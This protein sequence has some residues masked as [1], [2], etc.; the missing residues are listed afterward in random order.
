MIKRLFTENLALK[1]SAVVLA[2]ILWFFVMSKGQSEISLNVPVEYTN[3]P[4]GL[5]ITKR[6]VNSV[7]VVIRTYES[8]GKNIRPDNVRVYADVSKAKSGEGFF[9]IKSDNVKVPFGATVLDIDPSTVKAFFE[10]TLS[11]KVAVEPDIT[12][13]PAN[14]YYVKAVEVKPEQVLIEGP[15]SEVNKVTTIRTEPVGVTGI[16]EDISK[17]VGLEIPRGNIR[18]KVERAD[19]VV[20]IGRR[21]K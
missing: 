3:V 4:S 5:E 6:T 2:V 13:S 12:G 9:S 14:G 15:R 17:N 16:A 7:N 10:E 11:R 19:V 21:G 1:T 20:R 8:L 18:S